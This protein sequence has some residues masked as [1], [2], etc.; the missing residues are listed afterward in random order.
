MVGFTFGDAINFFQCFIFRQ[1]THSAI[2]FDDIRCEWCF[3]CA[4]KNRSGLAR[5]N[6][7]NPL[8][9]VVQEGCAG[10]DV[11]SGSSHISKN[12]GINK[13]RCHLGETKWQ[14]F[15]AY[16]LAHQSGL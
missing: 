7:L 14:V 3:T 5:A 16:A 8:A 2:A 15:R 11:R 1:G 9:Q 13:I 6:V 4:D 12:I 10:T